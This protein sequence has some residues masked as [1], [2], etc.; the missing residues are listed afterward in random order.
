MGV[1]H[2]NPTHCRIV[3]IEDDLPGL[4]VDDVQWETMH[5]TAEF[6]QVRVR[7]NKEESEMPNNCV[8]PGSMVK[9]LLYYQE[10]QGETSQYFLSS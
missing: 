3:R 6:K 9:L 7:H 1:I 2:G 10:K 5:T 4:S 8:G